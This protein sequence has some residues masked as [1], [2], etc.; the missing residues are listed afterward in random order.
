[1]A[2]AKHKPKATHPWKVVPLHPASSK[3]GAL[4]PGHARMGEQIVGW[5]GR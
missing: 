2:A 4:P 1:M 5:R 3:P